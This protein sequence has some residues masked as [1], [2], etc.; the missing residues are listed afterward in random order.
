MS[1]FVSFNSFNIVLFSPIEKPLASSVIAL[2]SVFTIEPSTSGINTGKSALNLTK[3]F[4]S[5][6]TPLERCESKITV[7]CFPI[8]GIICKV[9]SKMNAILGLIPFFSSAVIKS[10]AGVIKM[11]NVIGV[12]IAHNFD[13]T[14]IAFNRP[15]L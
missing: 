5:V 13:V 12:I 15:F 11:S 1:F 7:A 4:P 14:A 3:T 10:F 6:S 8:S 9:K 2:S